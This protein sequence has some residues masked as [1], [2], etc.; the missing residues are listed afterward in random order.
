MIQLTDEEIGA[1]DI[2]CGMS[3]I[4]GTE[5]YYSYKYEYHLLKAQLKKVVKW[6]I[7]RR[8]H[9]EQKRGALK[10]EKPN[11]ISG[12][13]ILGAKIKAFQQVIDKCGQALFEEV[14]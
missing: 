9:F 4:D 7:D 6:G 12:I 10:L 11:D 2:G 14:K 1:I 8:K 5:P 3:E 13:T